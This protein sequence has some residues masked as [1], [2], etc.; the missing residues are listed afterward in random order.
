MSFFD[1]V[2]RRFDEGTPVLK[3]YINGEVVIRSEEER[4]AFLTESVTLHIESCWNNLR[5]DRNALLAASDWTQVVDAPVDQKAWAEYRQTLRD[6][7][8]NTEDPE[9]PVWPNPPA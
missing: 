9:N 4:T 7:P 5:G 2:Y 1:D 3:E 8:E 6:L